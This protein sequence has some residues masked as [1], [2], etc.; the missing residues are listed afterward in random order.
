MSNLAFGAT[1]QQIFSIEPPPPFY[2]NSRNSTKTTPENSKS[3]VLKGLKLFCFVNSANLLDVNC[4]PLSLTRCLS[5][6]NLKRKSHKASRSFSL[7]TLGIVSSL[8]HFEW[9]STTTVH[10]LLMNGPAK[11]MCTLCHS[12]TSWGNPKLAKVLAEAYLHVDWHGRQRQTVLAM[13]WSI[14]GHHT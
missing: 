11:S 3:L 8:S 14:P 7:V 4:E 1:N 5:I 2:R 10:I 13:L 12:L 6:L 9:P